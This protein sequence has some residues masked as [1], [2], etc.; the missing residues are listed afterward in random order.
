MLGFLMFITVGCPT[1]ES[2]Q[3]A[4]AQME[5]LIDFWNGNRSEARQTYE[6]QVLITLLHATEDQ[7]GPWKMT[8][9]LAEYP[10]A[11]EGLVFTEKGHDLFVTIAGNRN[12][13]ENDKIVVP[14]PLTRNLLGYR[15][16]IIREAEADEF[17]AIDTPEQVK[18]LIHGI[19]KTWSDATI[20]RHNGFGVAE[21]G[22]FE[23]IFDRLA[24]G[25][26]DYSAYGANEVLWVYENRASQRAG[27]SIDE[28]L[29]FVYPFPLVFY[30][31]PARTDLAERIEVGLKHIMESGEL[32]AIYH[33]HYGNIVDDL[34][35]DK[36]QIIILENPL[37][38]EEYRDL[39]PDLGKL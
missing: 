9:S 28:N 4:S 2:Q 17:S 26:F 29:L 11:E 7:Y 25:R 6:R 35:L 27:L 1:I 12:F 15:V 18:Q 34:G 14:Y 5:T 30:I 13:G 33:Q 10:G 37:A 19:P 31:S 39:A 3:Q 8:E 36:R 20:F 24:A 38:P 16:A 22:D 21:E 32:D 23:D